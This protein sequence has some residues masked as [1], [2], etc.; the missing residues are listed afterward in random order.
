M[1]ILEIKNLVKHYGDVKAV[2]GIS[3][4]IPKGICFGLLGP[5]GAGKTTTIEVVEGIIQPTSGE[6]FY[7]EQPIG[8]LF[9]QE[10]GIQ[11]QATSLQEFLTVR[12]TITL[13]KSLY[14]KTMPWEELISLCALEDILDRDNQKLSGGQKQRML[15][16]LALVND[17]E[18]VFLDEPTTGL[19]PQA[20]RNFWDLVKSIRE[21]NKTII[22]TTHYMDEAYELC[23]EII[24][25][26]KGKIIAQGTPE[27]LLKNHFG[28][29]VI[30]LPVEDAGSYLDALPEAQYVLRDGKVEIQTHDSHETISAMLQAGA[31][32]NHLKLRA[33]SLED[34]FIALTGKQ[35]RQ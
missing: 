18:I 21:R 25:V 14:E 22:L 16:A 10:A 24:I 19:D 26:D 32:L 34:L 5:N 15:L 7:K 23:D 31:T 30:Q 17:P 6:V 28:D 35:L 11:F 1:S 3:F 33:W 8:E 4:H 2:N 13:F 9:R 27:A 12:E 20:R 29:T